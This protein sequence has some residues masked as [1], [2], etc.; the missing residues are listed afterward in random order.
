MRWLIVVALAS[1]TLLAGAAASTGEIQDQV[2]D[3][4]K[5]GGEGSP[6]VPAPGSATP[7]A[8]P[9]VPGVDLFAASL[10]FASLIAAGTKHVTRENV[11]EH[12]TRE[13]IHS[14]LW[15]TGSAHLRRI[16]D[17]LDLSTT[18]ATWH[19]DKLV[20]A[21]LVG[22]VKENGY[23]MYYPKGGGRILREQCLMAAQLQSDNAQAVVEYVAENPGSHQREI[24]RALDVNHGTARW[25]LSR[26]AE[27]GILQDAKEGRT[28]TYRLTEKAKE[29]LSARPPQQLEGLG[30]VA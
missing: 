24:A 14:F 15:E 29:V 18:N 4:L 7:D 5:D 13:E 20:K 8:S 12:E 27:A 10:A 22:E 11:L 2:E 19:L 26:L 28:T 21:G 25:H 6:G 30:Q 9:A 16:S 17:A 23:R 1:L 3:V